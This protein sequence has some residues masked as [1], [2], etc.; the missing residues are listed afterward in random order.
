MKKLISL[1]AALLISLCLLQFCAESE[2]TLFGK[3]EFVKEQSTDIAPWRYRQPELVIQQNEDSITILEKWRERQKIAFVDSIRFKPDS[4]VHQILVSSQI[5][6]QNWFMGVL[7]KTG[8]F[9]QV[10]ANW[11]T[12][13][14][15]LK[16]MTE[17]IVEISQG[18]T[19]LKT[20]RDYQLEADGDILR[21]DEYRSTRPQPVTLIF[22]RAD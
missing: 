11:L 3:W 2:R 17:Q 21:V 20:T 9:K 22:R 10:T 5:W 15:R 4:T 16:V 7:A 6:P 19:R 18:E 13:G 14:Q 8:S 1:I 12:P